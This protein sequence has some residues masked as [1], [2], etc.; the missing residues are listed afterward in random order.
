MIKYTVYII[1]YNIKHPGYTSTSITKIKI[2]KIYSFYLIFRK[3]NF[4]FK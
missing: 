1:L 3:I 4:E 2:D